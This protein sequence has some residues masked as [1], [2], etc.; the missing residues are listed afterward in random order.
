[1]TP[2][3]PPTAS[4]SVIMTVE[5]LAATVTSDGEETIAR[6]VR[7]LRLSTNVVFAPVSISS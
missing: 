4:V 2:C 7:E 3:A 5:V 6:R 1:M